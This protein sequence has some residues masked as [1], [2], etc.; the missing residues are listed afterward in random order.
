[1]DTGLDNKEAG[2]DNRETGLDNG[3][4]I[5]NYMWIGVRFL[6]VSLRFF[7]ALLPLV[8]YSGMGNIGKVRRSQKVTKR[9]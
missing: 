6:V 5:Y 1:M 7:L 4:T 9:S 3:E 2:L 8:A